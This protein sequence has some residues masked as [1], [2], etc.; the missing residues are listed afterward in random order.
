VDWICP[1]TSLIA[2]SAAKSSTTGRE[3]LETASETVRN[4]GSRR[5]WGAVPAPLRPGHRRR[6][7][8]AGTAESGNDAV[9]DDRLPARLGRG[10]AAGAA[11]PG[12]VDIAARRTA[13]APGC[14]S[15]T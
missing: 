4:G 6:S 2:Q 1:P 14:E 5:G 7:V 9:V 8:R 12:T 13:A 3:S 11:S 15:A 10:P